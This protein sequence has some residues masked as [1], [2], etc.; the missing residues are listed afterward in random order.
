MK[1]GAGFAVIPF[2]KK[3][4]LVGADGAPTE[5]YK[6]FRNGSTGGTAIG[7]AIKIGYR[8]LGR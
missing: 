1:G 8:D 7:S 6:R 4:G 3:I 2:F 5:L